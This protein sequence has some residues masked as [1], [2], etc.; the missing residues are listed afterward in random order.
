[1][2]INVRC[3]DN[4]DIRTNK[5][6]F[7]YH[8]VPAYIVK[9]SGLKSGHDGDKGLSPFGPSSVNVDKVCVGY[10]RLWTGE[11]LCV[12]VVPCG[13]GVGKELSDGLIVRLVLGGKIRG[14]YR[15]EAKPKSKRFDG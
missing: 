13:I 1:M 5:A 10:G 3:D 2:T 15:S 8:G 6:D 14:R 9:W 4:C 7:L 12:M 11:L